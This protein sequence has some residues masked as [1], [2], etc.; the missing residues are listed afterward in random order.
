MSDE[1]IQMNSLEE[2]LEEKYNHIYQ[3]MKKEK[4]TI[5]YP[6]NHIVFKQ[7]KYDDKIVGFATVDLVM[8]ELPQYCLSECYIMPEYRGHDILFDFIIHNISNPNYEFT[9]RRPNRAIM[10]L[11]LKYNLAF[12]L[13][14]DIII[15]YIRLN[16]SFSEAVTNKKTRKLYKAVTDEYKDEVI[17]SSY[18]NLTL[19]CVEFFDTTGYYTR[20]NYTLCISKPRVDDNRKYRLRR[21]FKEVSEKKLDKTALAISKHNTQIEEFRQ[22]IDNQLNEIYSVDNVIGTSDKLN[23]NIIRILE[24]NNLSIND[25]FNL[26]EIII[27]KLGNNEIFNSTIPDYFN[28]LVATYNVQKD[29]YI[30]EGV[31]LQEKNGIKYYDNGFMDI[32]ICPECNCE[33]QDYNRA[34]SL[35][36]YN[37][38][39]YWTDE[40]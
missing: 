21:K 14:K 16:V 28:F 25:G 22:Q 37:L 3:A 23:D 27:E 8:G 18:Y 38:S 32:L 12:S 40:N 15:S 39:K 24:A 35:C 1:K 19:A 5:E 6:D 26:R 9:I 2:F 11:L 36:G 34:C 4:Y 33:N 17:S 31:E 20:D 7:L 29:E 30:P 13:N 10:N